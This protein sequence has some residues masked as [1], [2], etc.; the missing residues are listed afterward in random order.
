MFSVIFYRFNQWQFPSSVQQVIPSKSVSLK[1]QQQ[2]LL[3]QQPQHQPHNFQRNI[4]IGLN[5][6]CDAE[7]QNI[8]MNCPQTPPHQQVINN[9]NRCQSVPVPHNPRLLDYQPLTPQLNTLNSAVSPA[10][11]FHAKRNLNS[12]FDEPLQPNQRLQNH[13]SLNIISTSQDRIVPTAVSNNVSNHN[14]HILVPQSRFPLIQQQTTGNSI[15]HHRKVETGGGI[16][17][18]GFALNDLSTPEEMGD[19]LATGLEDIDGDDLIKSLQHP[20]SN[21]AS[22]WSTSTLMN[23]S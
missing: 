8:L 13:D 3:Q 6:S 11:Q 19:I 15:G 2:A 21:W 1:S 22:D 18:L 4:R 12:L 16:Y 5:A 20:S 9:N 7:L 23:I 14:Q 10:H 17:G